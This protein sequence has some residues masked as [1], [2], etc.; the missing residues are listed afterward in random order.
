MSSFNNTTGED[1]KSLEVSETKAIRQEDKILKYF[2]EHPDMALSSEHIWHN[3]YL[4]DLMNN[5]P[6]TSCRRAICNLVRDGHLSI[7]GKTLGSYGKAIFTYKFIK[8]V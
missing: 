2:K 7:C 3:V 1:N 4:S 6:L 5:T 8:P